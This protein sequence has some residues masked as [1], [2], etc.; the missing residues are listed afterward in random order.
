MFDLRPKPASKQL[1]TEDTARL[2]KSAVDPSNVASTQTHKSRAPGLQ[3]RPRKSSI[4]TV[5]AFRNSQSSQGP[6]ILGRNASF[7][8][9]PTREDNYDIIMQPE[10]RPISQ[11]QLVA[12]VKGTYA[13][14]VM[15]EAKCIDVGNKQAA[16][17]QAD[18]NSQPK[19]NNE[20]WQ[21]LI[22]LHRT[23]LQEYHD[24]FFAS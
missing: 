3:P 7:Q 22:A 11:E 2:P 8:T 5:Q 13:G 14:L 9:L 23:L 10:T 12:E 18:P 1:W 16:L 4:A 20:Q 6:T 21:A 24:F 15:I 17:P 19:L